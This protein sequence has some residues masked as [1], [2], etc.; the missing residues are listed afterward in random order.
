M[1]QEILYYMDFHQPIYYEFSL[2]EG[3]FSADLIDPWQMTVTPTQG[4]FSGKA[5]LRLSGKPYQAVRFRRA[6]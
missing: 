3:S 5:K 2:P 6:T 1:T 4:S